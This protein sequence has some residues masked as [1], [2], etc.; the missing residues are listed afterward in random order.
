[1]PRSVHFYLRMHRA[2]MASHARRGEARRYR[3]VDRNANKNARKKERTRS[4]LRVI[5]RAPNNNGRQTFRANVDSYSPERASRARN[6]CI[7]A[8]I[9]TPFDVECIWSLPRLPSLHVS[10]RSR[11]FS[12]PF[13]SLTFSQTIGF[14]IVTFHDY[15]AR[16]T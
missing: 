8:A 2:P 5:S 10:L 11:A 9:L 12:Q 13:T 3:G 1:V 6:I 15:M 16:L 14:G 7:I 4:T